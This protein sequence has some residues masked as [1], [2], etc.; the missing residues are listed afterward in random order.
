MVHSDC[1]P[2]LDSGMLYYQPDEVR[3]HFCVGSSL[4]WGVIPNGPGSDLS[5]RPQEGCINLR[6]HVTWQGRLLQAS[7]SVCLALGSH[8]SGLVGHVT[9]PP[10]DEA[11][12]V[13]PEGSLV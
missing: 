8:G 2:N 4:Y 5:P 11:D 3:P 7:T 6:G 1:S 10:S 9:C 12:S 13:V